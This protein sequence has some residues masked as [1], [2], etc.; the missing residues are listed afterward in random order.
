MTTGLLFDCDEQVANYTF[1]N[2]LKD[3]RPYKYD[4]A[5][6]L[7][8]PKGLCGAA[9]FHYWNGHNVEL[10]YLGYDTITVGVLRGLARFAI[11]TFNPSR[12]TVVTAKRN[13]RLIRTLQRVGLKVEGTQRCYYGPVDCVR[14]TGVRLVMFRDEL[15]ALARVA[16]LNKV[17]NPCLWHRPPATPLLQ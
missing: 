3:H 2:L 16:P 12:V 10:T 6:G 1:R 11:C 15:N 5:V 7:I 17:H 4:R 8:G 9:L 13:K 14:N